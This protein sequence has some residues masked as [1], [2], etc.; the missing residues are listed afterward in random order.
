MIPLW[1]NH[2]LLADNAFSSDFFDLVV[3]IGNNPVTIKQTHGLG[4]V[5]PDRDGIGKGIGICRGVRLHF[6]VFC[7]GSDFYTAVIFCDVF[8]HAIGFSTHSS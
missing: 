7:P 5:I 3:L 6:Q 2:W 8:W 1:L 4:A